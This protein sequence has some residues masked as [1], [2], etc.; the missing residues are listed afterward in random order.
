MGDYLIK[1]AQIVTDG[2]ITAADLLI[3]G[4]YIERIDAAFD[5]KFKVTEIDAEGLQLLPGIIDDQ[6]HFRE[7]G[8][9]HKATIYTEAKA[10]VAGGV[11][12]YM[13]M[14]NVNPLTLT[15]E[16]LEEKYNIAARTS[17][18]NFSFYMG[19]GHS[20]FDELMKVE[21]NRVCGIKIFMG[22]STGDMLV[23][24]PDTL[25][26][27]FRERNDI[28]I[29]THCEDDKLVKQR[30]E[31][32]M[33]KYGE[34]I[35]FECHAE[36]R[37]ETV[38]LNSSSYAV[39]LAKKYNSR[40][41]ILHISTAD[42]LSLFTNQIPLEDKR[43]T[44]EVCVHHLWFDKRDY[45]RLGSRIKCNP[46]IK[47]AHH[48]QALFEA[49][50]DNRIDIIA[51][52]HA[53]HTIEEKSN[54]YLK[55]PSGLPLVQHTLNVMLTFYHQGKISLERIVE[56]MCHAPAECFEVKSRGY[57]REGYFADAVLADTNKEW[58]VTP[59]NLLYKCGWSPFE[60]YTFKGE[61]LKTFVNGHL[62]YNKGSFDESIKG[63][64]LEFDR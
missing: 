38:C 27:I 57:L 9:T 63:E 12:S 14:P 51:T 52:D 20:N 35:P 6:V 7:P 11:T 42:E 21:R 55:A 61:V 16:L 15:I 25:E 17:L 22:S 64:R 33:A 30:T 50:L 36:I 49:L 48:K 45:E 18:A 13:E 37:N 40:L 8:L 58:Q 28:L 56:K 19:T 41:H 54:S 60:G 2:K 34:N 4:K 23:D 26:K 24:D 44:N 10:A 29:A 46:A 31:E 59:Q 47:E 1:N 62:A 39:S 43:I 5:V 3:R 32:Y 53:P